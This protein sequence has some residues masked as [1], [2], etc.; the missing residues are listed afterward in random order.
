MGNGKRRVGGVAAE[1]QV[2]EW[3]VSEQVIETACSVQPEAKNGSLCKAQ[4]L[5]GAAEA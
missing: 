3:N 4:G 2:D 5:V 1:M